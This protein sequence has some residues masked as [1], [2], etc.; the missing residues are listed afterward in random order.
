MALLGK[1]VGRSSGA[2]RNLART[3]R[4]S[5]G[6]AVNSAATS[7]AS[8]LNMASAG[9]MGFGSA[10]R[11]ITGKLARGA[12]AGLGAMSRRPKTTMAAGAGLA[13]YMGYRSMKG[14]QNSP[15]IG[16]E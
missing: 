6:R 7:V 9:A 14:S 16:L 4:S 11:G 1:M 8:G 12:G 2:A 10:K 5:G 15:I 3:A 13:G